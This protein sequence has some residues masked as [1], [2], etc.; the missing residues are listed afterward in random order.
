MTLFRC[1]SF[2]VTSRL[3]QRES[4]AAAEPIAS[5]AAP[6]VRKCTATTLRTETGME[7]HSTFLAMP[8]PASI[9][10]NTGKRKRLRPVAILARAALLNLFQATRERF[11]L[12]GAEF[13]NQRG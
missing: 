1:Y 4:A 6:G 3:P 7:S 5:L 12:V 11:L 8:S 9:P 2:L 10:I 13:A